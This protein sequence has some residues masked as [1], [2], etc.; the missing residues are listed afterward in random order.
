MKFLS[1]NS[2]SAI[3]LQNLVY[4]KGQQKNNEV[5]R[6]MLK[7]EQKGFCAYTEAYL[8]RL[9]TVV[10]EHFNSSLKYN[11]D[12]YNYYAVIGRCNQYK[13][14]KKYIGASF[15]QSPMFF[16]NKESLN[17]RI[18]FVNNIYEAVDPGDV[19]AENLIDFLGLN[20]PDLYEERIEHL[21]CLREYFEL[22]NID[23]ADK[24]A[25]REF[26]SEAEHRKL[27]SYITAIEKEFDLELEDI[28]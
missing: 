12:Y 14:D 28:L 23:L 5:L 11:D 3:L 22:S 4:K 19:D 6:N 10:V 25:I 18:R 15:F 26:L 13:K 8:S 7:E 9:Q 17:S 2:H 27:L 20:H 24:A 1:K 21:K 16:Q